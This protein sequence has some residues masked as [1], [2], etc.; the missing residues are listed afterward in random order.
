MA[1]D[2][3]SRLGVDVK[4]HADDR[5]SEVSGAR[6]VAQDVAARW[7]TVPG[8]HPDDPNVGS[9]WLVGYLNAGFTGDDDPKLYEIEHLCVQEALKERRVDDITVEVTLLRGDKPGT[10]TLRIRG[11]GETADGPFEVVLAAN[12]LTVDVISITAGTG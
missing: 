7:E 4:Y 10:Y 2:L 5:F 12:Q 6:C 3:N 8:G 1:F 11:N 9:V